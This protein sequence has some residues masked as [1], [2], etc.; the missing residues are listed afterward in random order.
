MCTTK[1]MGVLMLGAGIVTTQQ[2]E[3]RELGGEI[4]EF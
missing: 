2:R 1:A 3:F 4:L